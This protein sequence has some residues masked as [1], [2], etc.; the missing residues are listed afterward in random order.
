MGA[1]SADPPREWV[2]GC[3]RL[4]VTTRPAAIQPISW[5][6]AAALTWKTSDIFGCHR[7]AHLARYDMRTKAAPCRPS[8]KR[9]C[10]LASDRLA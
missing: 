10:H 9:P 2:E 4:C 1:N 5:L 6:Q 3:A 8:A 7:K